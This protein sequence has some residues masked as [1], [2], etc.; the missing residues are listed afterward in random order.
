MRFEYLISEKGKRVPGMERMVRN[1][2]RPKGSQSLPPA[3]NPSAL[4]RRP[5]ALGAEQGGLTPGDGASHTQAWG[6]ST[7]RA[8]HEHFHT[9]QRPKLGPATSG[10]LK[11]ITWHRL[12]K[13]NLGNC[14]HLPAFA[15][16]S[17]A[18]SLRKC[19]LTSP[20]HPCHPQVSRAVHSPVHCGQRSLLLKCTH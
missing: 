19:E 15:V 4:G 1:C 7:S 11:N 2:Q 13:G 18:F 5:A 12:F 16:W 14:R 10:S 9:M 20:W 8:L 3:Q 6:C 17:A